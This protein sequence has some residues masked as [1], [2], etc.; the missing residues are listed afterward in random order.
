VRTFSDKEYL[1]M[2]TRDGIVKRSNLSD[3][4]RPRRGGII[5][6]TLREKDE[7]IRVRKTDGKSEL[8]LATSD[9]QSIRFPE[10]E[11]REIGRTGQGVRGIDLRDNDHVVAFSLCDRPTVLTVCEN[12]Y[13]KRT[14]L[15]EFR[16]QGR[17]GSG[18]INI[19]TEGRN[20]AVVGV[21]TVSD[22]D[23]LLF[24]SSA[25]KVI[26]MPVKDISV[27][28]RN[29]QGVR[30]M[31]LD[32][33]EKVVAIEHLIP[34]GENGNGNGNGELKREGGAG[35][36]ESKREGGPSIMEIKKES[37]EQPKSES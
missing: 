22:E 23:E 21:K 30:L 5:A 7:L 4:S 13:G 31:K 20:G 26:R 17:G 12:G 36:S 3:Y 32:E 8:L 2:A 25:N 9:G 18:V 33:G 6:I 15:E 27:I 19:K 34:E 24:I 29:T 37:A 35:I 14:P 16:L 28:G 11:V 10:E 1:V